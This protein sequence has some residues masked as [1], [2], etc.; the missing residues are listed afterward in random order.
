MLDYIHW[1]TMLDRH[2]ALMTERV[3]IFAARLTKVYYALDTKHWWG[4]PFSL[5]AMAA[6]SILLIPVVLVVAAYGWALFLVSKY[7]H[8]AYF[9]YTCWVRVRRWVRAFVGCAIMCLLVHVLFI[10]LGLEATLAT[11]LGK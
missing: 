10:A 7:D 6:L 8:K 3:R 9:L 1:L 11:L 4:V 2:G 5:V